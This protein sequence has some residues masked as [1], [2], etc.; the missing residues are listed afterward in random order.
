VFDIKSEKMAK[1]IY[2]VDDDPDFDGEYRLPDKSVI[3]VGRLGDEDFERG[4]VRGRVGR[5]AIPYRSEG[6]KYMS[7]RHAIFRRQ[8]LVEGASEFDL[9]VENNCRLGTFVNE[10]LIEGKTPI[11]DGDKVRFG[12]RGVVVSIRDP[13]V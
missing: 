13:N 4:F 11:N 12:D 1:E 5:L 7:R 2:L 3:L 9:S 10:E 6:K 8:D